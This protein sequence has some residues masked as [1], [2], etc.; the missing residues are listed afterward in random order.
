MFRSDCKRFIR[1]GFLILSEHMFFVRPNL[2]KLERILVYICVSKIV[3]FVM[4]PSSR[5]LYKN[6]IAKSLLLTYNNLTR[7]QSQTLKDI[8]GVKLNQNMGKYLG[9]PIKM[10]VLVRPVSNIFIKY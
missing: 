3:V 10:V 5:V 2:L 6:K 4:F 8:L 7:C 1:L 9:V